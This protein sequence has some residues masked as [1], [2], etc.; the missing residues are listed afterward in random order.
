[1]GLM[2]RSNITLRIKAR[3][4]AYFDTKFGYFGTGILLRQNLQNLQI[5]QV[6]IT[7]PTLRFRLTNVKIIS[8]DT[9]HIFSVNAPANRTYAKKR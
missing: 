7:N 2:R 6:K 4:V 9:L 3:G 1:M 5:E 8:T